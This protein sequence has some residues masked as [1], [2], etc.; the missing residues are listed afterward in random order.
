INFSGLLR[1]LF[2]QLYAQSIRPVLECGIVI[3]S[4]TKTQLKKLEQ[5]QN[6]LRK[7]MHYPTNLSSMNER[8]SVLQAKYITRSQCLPDDT[9]FIQ[10]HSSFN[11][12]PMK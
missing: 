8:T 9:L 10:L 4:F 11:Y 3:T 6:K 1:I 7:V 12:Q 2:S 5:S